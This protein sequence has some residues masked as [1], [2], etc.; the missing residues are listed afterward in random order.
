MKLCEE[1]VH[2]GLEVSVQLFKVGQHPPAEFQVVGFLIIHMRGLHVVSVCFRNT[3]GPATV[4]SNYAT[5]PRSSSI[6]DE[7]CNRVL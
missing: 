5:I 3:A 1:P 2:A 6:P 7:C 4:N